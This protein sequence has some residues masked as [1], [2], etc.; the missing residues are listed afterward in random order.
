M[1]I[2]AIML[3]PVLY[4]VYRV[5]LNTNPKTVVTRI[6]AYSRSL[7]SLVLTGYVIETF[8]EMDNFQ[9]LA[10]GLMVALCLWDLYCTFIVLSFY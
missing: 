7:F 3:L 6:Y 2:L 4:Y 10:I 1:A 5:P 8:Y 9:G